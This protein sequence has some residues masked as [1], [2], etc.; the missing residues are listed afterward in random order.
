LVN[1]GRIL[2]KVHFQEARRRSEG[3]LWNST[4]RRKSLPHHFGYLSAVYIRAATLNRV[5]RPLQ[6]S[7][8]IGH[9]H[10]TS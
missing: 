7:M 9:H 5:R 4:S 8:A 10:L 2:D 3:L 6:H 1:V